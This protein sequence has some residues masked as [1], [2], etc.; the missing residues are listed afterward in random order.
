MAGDTQ[1]LTGAT[2]LPAL[3]E[4]VALS[5]PAI[6]LNRTKRTNVESVKLPTRNRREEKERGLTGSRHRRRRYENVTLAHNPHAVPAMAQD[7]YPTLPHARSFPAPSP[8]GFKSQQILP[9]QAAPDLD[10]HSA[11]MGRFHAPLKGIHRTFKRLIGPEEGQGGSIED[12]IRTIQNEIEQ[13]LDG[14][15]VFRAASVDDSSNLRRICLCTESAGESQYIQEVSRTPYNLVWELAPFNRF[16]VHCTA[17]YYRVPSFTKTDV[18]GRQVVYLLWPSIGTSAQKKNAIYTPSATDLSSDAASDH[19]AMS[20]SFLSDASA[21][22]S[23][24]DAPLPDRRPAW[25]DSSARR[26][27]TSGLLPLKLGRAPSAISEEHD[28]DQSDLGSTDDDISHLALS[29]TSL[30]VDG[31]PDETLQA[32]ERAVSPVRSASPCKM[33]SGKITQIPTRRTQLWSLPTVG[34]IEWVRA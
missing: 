26:R 22:A 2:I 11:D 25:D 3:D 10:L 17:R 13:W 6:L 24:V 1:A 14:S 31:D 15:Q 8:A 28:G 19:D 18:Q 5:I 32:P 29:I 34:F 16:L 4:P 9:S 20:S 21:D 33:V 23:R 7:R 30:S 12:S 27:Q